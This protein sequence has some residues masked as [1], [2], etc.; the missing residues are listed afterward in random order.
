MA[1]AEFEKSDLYSDRE[2]I[3]LQLA[4]ALSNT[5]AN[6]NDELYA[7]LEQQF[8]TEALVELS[9]LIAWENYRSRFNRTFNVGSDSLASG[10]VCLIPSAL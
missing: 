4:R 5:P 1:L 6:V 7:Q 3:A 9:S 10:D 8:S 2:K